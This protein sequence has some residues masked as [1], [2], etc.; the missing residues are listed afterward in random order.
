MTGPSKVG[1]G[2]DLSRLG[3]QV[4]ARLTLLSGR[5]QA[6]CLE[7][8][9]QGVTGLAGDGRISTYFCRRLGAATPCSCRRGGAKPPSEGLTATLTAAR[10][11]G[12]VAI[13]GTLGRRGRV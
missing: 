7:Q 6:D 4:E 12:A 2:S 1:S 5:G 3:L 11:R 9:K 10:L 13:A 8:N